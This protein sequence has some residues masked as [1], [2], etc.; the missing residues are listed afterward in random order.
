MNQPTA[1]FYMVDT[2]E[3]FPYRLYAPQQDNSTVIVSS[4]PP[5]AWPLNNPTQAWIEGPGC[6]SG[7]IRTTPSGKI[8]YGDCK[9]EFGRCDTMTGQEQHYWS[10]TTGSIRSSGTGWIRRT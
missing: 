8:V 10:S 7:Q 9:G 3:Q 5:Y 4:L 2:D 6:E 1:E